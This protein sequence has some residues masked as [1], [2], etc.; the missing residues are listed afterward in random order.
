MLKNAAIQKNLDLDAQEKVQEKALQTSVGMGKRV[1]DGL[2][3]FTQSNED[4]FGF[5]DVSRVDT[6]AAVNNVNTR[7]S[8]GYF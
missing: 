7:I 5:S 2:S 4:Q 1:K 8:S 3:Q 6:A